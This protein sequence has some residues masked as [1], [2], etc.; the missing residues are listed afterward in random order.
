MIHITYGTAAPDLDDDLYYDEQPE[1]T[2]NDDHE[3]SNHKLPP[4]IAYIITKRILKKETLLVVNSNIWRYEKWTGRFRELQNEEAEILIESHYKK[5]E[6]RMAKSSLASEIKTR[7]CRHPN[8]Q[9]EYE[10][11]NAASDFINCE[12]GVVGIGLDSIRLLDHSPEYRFTYCINA[13]YK[14]KNVETPVFDS[15]CNTSL[16]GDNK[17]R[18]LLLQIIGYCC[19]DMTDAKKAFF[20]KGEPDSG[21]SVMLNFLENLVGLDAVSNIPL[22]ELGARFNKAALFG[23]KLNTNG[24]IKNDKFNY[25]SYLKSM[26]GGDRIS[27]EF[28]HGR[29]FS[30]T[31]TAKLIFAGNSRLCLK[32]KK[33]QKPSSTEFVC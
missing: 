24:E 23:K 22:H 4:D 26:T 6:Y 1:N 33:L 2:D 18:K 30:Y 7:I 9:A 25:L 13:K 29:N 16:N 15:F 12:N 27:A 21:K 3:D 10:D 11:F 28:K 20:L 17:K 19:S 5:K 14:E 32:K 8:L 31:P